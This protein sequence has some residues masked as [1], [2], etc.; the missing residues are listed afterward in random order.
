MTAPQIDEDLDF[1]GSM[2]AATAE[3]E[4]AKR[5]GGG[6]RRVD[7]FTLKDQETALARLLNDREATPENPVSWVSVLMHGFVPTKP[8]PA[9]F[10]GDTWPKTM[11][12]ACRGDKI[13]RKRY[14]QGCWICSNVLE[15][16]G[17]YKG[18]PVRPSLKVMT[19][20]VLREE[21]VEGGQTYVVDKM[22]DVQ[23]VDADGKV[24]EG[25]TISVPH[26][27][28]IEQGHKNFFSKLTGMS[29]RW[30]TIMDRD[31]VITRRGADRTTDYMIG[32]DD[33]FRVPDPDDPSQTVVYDLRDPRFRRRY[34]DLGPDLFPDLRLLVAQKASDDLY[35]RF[36]IPGAGES[37]RSAG[38][39][40]AAPRTDAD[41]ERVA[42][43]RASILDRLQKPADGAPAGEQ[44]VAARY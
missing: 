15:T 10:E 2:G 44:R 12:A 33:P 43:T 4:A 38:A 39:G 13:F 1:T 9:D 25:E 26:I 35:D 6:F 23:K 29:A 31:V 30:G 17:K 28:Q 11:S 8:K 3:E 36:F 7:F 34:V 32:A 22:H 19:L 37:P 16:E 5:T 18:K 41:P 21:V 27:V 20:A 14:P 24:V 42:A 40:P